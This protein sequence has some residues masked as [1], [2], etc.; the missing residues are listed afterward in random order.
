MYVEVI[1]MQMKMRM[2][3]ISMR[4]TYE[5]LEMHDY[6]QMSEYITVILVYL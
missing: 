6:L 3:K 1:G 4:I 5:V 2:V